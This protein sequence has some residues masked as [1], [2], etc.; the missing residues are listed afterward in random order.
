MVTGECEQVPE[1][2]GELII[3]IGEQETKSAVFLPQGIPGPRQ[4]VAFF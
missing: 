1:C 4:K 2:N 3:K